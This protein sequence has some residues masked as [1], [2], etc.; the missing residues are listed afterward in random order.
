MVAGKVVATAAVAQ[1]EEASEVEDWE[2][3]R[4][5]VPT[6]EETAVVGSGEAMAVVVM[7]EATG[8]EAH[9]AAAAAME[10]AAME[11]E[12]TV[13]DW[14]EGREVGRFHDT[15]DIAARPRCHRTARHTSGHWCASPRSR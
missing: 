12:A 15:R 1:V 4:A 7:G 3:V 13:E 10:E 9:M 8:E 5:R 6:E 11:G 2:V 14:V